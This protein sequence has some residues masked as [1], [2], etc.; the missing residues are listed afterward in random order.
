M[1]RTWDWQ[2]A[3][4]TMANLMTNL[5]GAR[6]E[7]ILKDNGKRFYKNAPLSADDVVEKYGPYIKD[8]SSYLGIHMVD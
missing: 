1:S 8:A 6:A 3:S 7:D 4:H 5:G 2:E